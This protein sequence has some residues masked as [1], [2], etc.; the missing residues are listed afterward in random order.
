MTMNH[1]GLL[2]FGM[3]LGA[4]SSPRT[5]TTTTQYTSMAPAESY[6]MDH[7]AEITLARSAAPE[8]ISRDAE[9]WTLG[10]HG[11][12]PAVKGTNGFVCIVERS[13]MSPFDAP[14]FW[15]PKLRGPICYNR[16]AAR[17]VMP[18][19]FKRTSLVLAGLSKAQIVD[20]TKAFDLSG[21]PALEAGGMSYM[22]SQQQYLGDQAGHWHPHLMFYTAQTDSTFWGSDVPKSPIILGPQAQGAPDPFSIFMVPVAKWSDGTR[23]Q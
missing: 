4:C 14:E 10:R 20:S 6:L 15:N 2:T 11:Y 7:D 17:T 5:P 3:A 1:V 13:W 21:L 18:R 16:P 22:L 19:T 12:E 8:A 23:A 9:V